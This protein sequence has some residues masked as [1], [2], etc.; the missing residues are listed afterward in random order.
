MMERRGMADGI[1]VV[2]WWKEGVW[3]MVSEWLDGG[4]KGY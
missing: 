1:R 3:P 2:G 4:K